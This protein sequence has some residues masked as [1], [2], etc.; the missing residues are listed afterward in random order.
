[1]EYNIRQI[2]DEIAKQILCWKYETPYDFYNSELTEENVRELVDDTYHVVFDNHDKL[3]GFYCTGAAAQVPT[4]KEFGAYDKDYVDIGLGLK[5]DLTGKGLGSSF[6]RFIIDHICEDRDY[7]KLRLTVAT[8]NK[9]AISLYTK[10][11]FVR[12]ISFHTDT[13]EF[14]TMVL[15]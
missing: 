12:E 4:G 7:Q 6:L 2:T 9:R 5:P 8:F 14:I 13:T 10:V 3:I 15:E 1:M 11:G